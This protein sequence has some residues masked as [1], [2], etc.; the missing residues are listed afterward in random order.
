[1]KKVKYAIYGAGHRGK[2]VLEYLG[3]ENVVVFIDSSD[4]KIGRDFCG[5]RIISLNEYKKKYMHCYIIIS[6]FHCKMII[7]KLIEENIFQF[8][9]VVNMPSEFNTNSYC[10]FEECYKH[11]KQQ[12]K[13]YVIYGLNAFSLMLYEYLCTDSKV[14]ITPANGDDEIVDWLQ[15]EY[16]NFVLKE[17]NKMNGTEEVLIAVRKINLKDAYLVKRYVSVDMLGYSDDLPIYYHEELEKFK[18]LFQDRKRCFITATG[19]SMSPFDLETLRKNNEFCIGVNSICLLKSAWKPNVF[20]VTDGLFWENH[21]KD[22]LSYA[23]DLTFLPD[24]LEGLNDKHDNIY[25]FHHAFRWLTENTDS[26]MFSEDVCQKI[27]GGAT[28]V[29]T[30]I[31]LA[32]Y[33]GFKEIYLLGVDCNYVQGSRNNHFMPDQEKDMVNYKYEENEVEKDMVTCYKIAKNYADSHG[34]KIYNA[35]RGGMLEVFERVNFDALFGA[36]K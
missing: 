27:F 3:A 18:N 9:P 22:I 12:G 24:I 6:P 31:Q 10:K 35:T 33:F 19:P 21:K 36:N 14:S 30:C 7:N 5:K 20:V 2:K 25:L 4:K 16:P 15:R 13:E 23:C 28:V 34:I 1:M 8:T 26:L 29:Y 17:L 11:F 32:V